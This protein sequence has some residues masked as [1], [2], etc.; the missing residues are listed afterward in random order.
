[1]KSATKLTLK[2]NHG[3]GMNYGDVTS[4]L[5]RELRNKKQ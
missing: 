5:K 2:I 1:M 4:N 3:D